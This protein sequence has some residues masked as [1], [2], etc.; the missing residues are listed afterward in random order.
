MQG[1]VITKSFLKRVS[2][3]RHVCSPGNKDLKMSIYLSSY[4]NRPSVCL[5]GPQLVVVVIFSAQQHCSHHYRRRGRCRLIS[6]LRNLPEDNGRSSPTDD[7]KDHTNG[8]SSSFLSAR[9]SESIHSPFPFRK[10]FSGCN[11]RSGLQFLLNPY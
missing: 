1:I 4:Y 3:R 5:N 9:V 6:S 11:T 7:S 8:L 2:P 10:S